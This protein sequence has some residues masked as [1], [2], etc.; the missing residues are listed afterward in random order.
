MEEASAMPQ[1]PDPDRAADPPLSARQKAQLL[2]E[3]RTIKRQT[4]STWSDGS[5]L[6]WLWERLTFASR[7]SRS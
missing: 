4:E 1:T 7:R 6:R 2:A 3:L 5:F